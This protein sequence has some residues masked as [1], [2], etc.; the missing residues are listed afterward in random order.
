LVLPGRD[1][2]GGRGK[3]R[4]N[5]LARGRRVAR[6]VVFRAASAY[7]DLALTVKEWREER[8]T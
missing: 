5:G 4:P 6:K 8:L 3:A 1:T 2:G 7:A